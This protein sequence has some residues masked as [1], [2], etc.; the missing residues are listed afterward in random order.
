MTIT[1]VDGTQIVDPMNNQLRTC[2]ELEE[3][4]GSRNLMYNVPNDDRVGTNGYYKKLKIGDNYFYFTKSKGT[5]GILFSTK[6]VNFNTSKGHDL[7]NGVYPKIFIDLPLE[8]DVKNYILGVD[9]DIEKK[10][11]TIK[12]EITSCRY[13]EDYKHNPYIEMVKSSIK[14]D[15]TY[16]KNAVAF[17]YPAEQFVFKGISLTK[18][19][20]EGTPIFDMRQG[21]DT[22]SEVA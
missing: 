16:K 3:L 22:V 9:S 18:F 8:V 7:D 19:K 4:D 5:E 12:V 2:F 21:I 14:N 17:V 13:F 1:H 11:N 20:E 6:Q 10:Y 15:G